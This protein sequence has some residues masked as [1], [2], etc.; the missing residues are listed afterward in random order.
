MPGIPGIPAE[1]ASGPPPVGPTALVQPPPANVTPLWLATCAAAVHVGGTDSLP[2]RLPP[3]A[4]AV[5]PPML[6]IL[7]SGCGD[8][9]AANSGRLIPPPGTAAP[10][11]PAA[12]KELISDSPPVIAGVTMP[13][14][15]YPAEAMPLKNWE[16]KN[17]PMGSPS[18]P[19]KKLRMPALGFDSGDVACVDTGKVSCCN[20]EG[21]VE[22][23]CDS[24]V[25]APD[26]VLVPAAFASVEDCSASA[27]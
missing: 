11:A 9:G 3:A 7:A 13:G 4:S 24:C 23:S 16:F 26:P 5:T 8:T 27:S 19:D 15:P 1:A 21:T 2:T 22:I 18:W 10:A 6:G 20:V 25:C 12:P 17:V 14:S